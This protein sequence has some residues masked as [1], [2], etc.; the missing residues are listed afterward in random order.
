MKFFLSIFSAFTRKERVAFLGVSVTGAISFVVVM[1]ILVA[2]ATM[3]VP[4]RGGEYSEGVVGQPAYVNPVTATGETDL[5]LV[6]MVYANIYD[7]A[8]S[9]NS[10]PDGR[11]WKIRLKENL[12]WQDGQKLTSDDV[13][14]TVASIQDQN[15]NSLLYASWQ[16]VAVSRTSELEFQ[17]SLANPYAFFSD[18]L[19][20][21]YIIPKHLF[22]NIPTGNWRLSDYNLKPVGSGPYKFLSYDKQPDGFVSSYHLAA[23]DGYAGQKPLIQNFDFEFFGNNGDLIKAFNGGQIDGFGN[24]SSNGLAGIGRPYDL[25]AWRTPSYYAVFFNQSKNLG[26]QDPAVRSAL[27][28]AIDRG[29]LVQAT[30]GGEGKPEYGPIPDGA[31]NFLPVMTT[32]S[33]EFASTTLTGAGW[34]MGST[35]FR[36]KMIQKTSV[37]LA[38]NLTVPNID[39]LVKTADIL[40][41]AWQ[42]IGIQANITT[43]TPENIVNGTIKNRDYES[44]LFGNILGASSDL[45]SF[46]DSSRRFSPG[47]NLAIYQNKKVD[48]LIESIRRNMSEASR[49][50][51]FADAENDII[52]DYPAVFLYSPDYLYVTNKNVQ[53]IKPGLLPDPSDRFREIPTWYLNTA[54]VL[55]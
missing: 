35:G 14:F 22:T 17:F 42:S 19:K 30:L 20:N 44:L 1:G 47:L 36:A 29:N 51:E 3:T 54:R 40:K 41:T 49:T 48:T 53:G 46:W 34:Q 12:L 50:Q 16:G 25:F 4:T 13:I 27:S 7:L 9:I 52:A 21:L 31:A 18:N 11:T 10:S 5:S 39:F 26:L 24:V 2:Q 38:L 45:Y 6:K 28:A 23:W 32:T 15:A 8:E 43:D 33:L 37:P 55:R